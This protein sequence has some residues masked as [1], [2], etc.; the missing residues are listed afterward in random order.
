MNKQFDK[1]NPKLAQQALRI[2]TEIANAWSLTD[3]EQCAILDGDVG[4]V[5]GEGAL[6]TT[7]V[8]LPE[9]LERVGHLVGMYRALHIIF[10][11]KEQADSWIRRPN[12]A[13]LF[14]GA[15]ALGL[16]CSGRA[17]DLA[18]VRQYLESQASYG[19]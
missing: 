13:L 17:S 1:M 10:S 7:T 11:S 3:K 2:F 16:L 12:E 15:P 6:D 8:R 9:T 14:G 18:L 4:S 19:H 5:Y